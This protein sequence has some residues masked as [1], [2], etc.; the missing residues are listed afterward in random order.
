MIVEVDILA[1]QG[2]W[3]L[4]YGMYSFGET[5][6]KDRFHTNYWLWNQHRE[7]A[8]AIRKSGRRRRACI[9]FSLGGNALSW[10]ANDD[11]GQGGFPMIDLLVAYDPSV[12]AL[13]EPIGNNVKRCIVHR[14]M[15]Y[16]FTSALYGRATF[17]SSQGGPP[18][19]EN[20]FTAD[21]LYVP[22]MQSLHAKTRA[23]LELLHDR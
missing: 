17:T 21:H 2:G 13:L 23:A 14:Q 5:L 15:G 7:V 20:R 18:I 19:E 9:G 10:I 22:Y 4:S 6:P 16:F 8:R 12:N 11:A 1:G 3:P